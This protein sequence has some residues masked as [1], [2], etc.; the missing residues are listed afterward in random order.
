MK[1]ARKRRARSAKEA[2]HNTEKGNAQ[3]AEKGLYIAR[4]SYRKGG[5]RRPLV[6]KEEVN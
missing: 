3:E 6:Q 1:R 4:G 5:G 2:R